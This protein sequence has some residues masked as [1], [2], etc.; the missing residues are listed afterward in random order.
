MAEPSLFIRRSSAESFFVLDPQVQGAIALSQFGQPW[1]R[2]S[3]L[4]NL[5]QGT[6]WKLRDLPVLNLNIRGC[7]KLAGDSILRSGDCPVAVNRP[8]A[9]G[10][11]SG[12]VEVAGAGATEILAAAGENKASGHEKRGAFVFHM[13][14]CVWGDRN[15]N[16]AA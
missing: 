15:S 9:R 6:L 5:Y 13:G 8:I 11:R 16:R 4:L 2:A 1:S 7:L 14:L 3:G 10:G 12:G